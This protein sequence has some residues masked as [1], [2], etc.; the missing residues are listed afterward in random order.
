MTI[1]TAQTDTTAQ[2]IIPFEFRSRKGLLS[3]SHKK[4]AQ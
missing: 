2:L 3:I 4:N 1:P